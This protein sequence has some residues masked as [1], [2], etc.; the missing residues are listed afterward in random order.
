MMEDSRSGTSVTPIQ[1]SVEA[2]EDLVLVGSV[3][4]IPRVTKGSTYYC[5]M[6]KHQT[7]N[8]L[9]RH[10]AKHHGEESND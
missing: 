5:Q 10:Y 1:F 2:R 7:F 6:Q 3:R 9:F 8:S 4:S